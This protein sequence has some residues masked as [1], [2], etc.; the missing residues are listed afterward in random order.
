MILCI[1]FFLSWQPWTR[2]NLFEFEPLKVI[3]HHENE[4]QLE[5]LNEIPKQF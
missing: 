3:Y 5:Q 2:T 4:F 1:V